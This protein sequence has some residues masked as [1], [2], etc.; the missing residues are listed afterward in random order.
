MPKCKPKTMNCTLNCVNTRQSISCSSC[1]DNK[2]K[3]CKNIFCK[4]KL[5]TQVL[6][7]KRDKKKHSLKWRKRNRLNFSP[8][9][10]SG[11][12]AFA[13]S[14]VSSSN[15]RKNEQKTKSPR[16]SSNRYEAARN[17]CSR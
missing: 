6:P 7:F 16:A 12:R 10:K 8:T 15:K 3:R 14:G 4:K 17:C 13:Q 2:D 5:P 1:V 9:V 11:A